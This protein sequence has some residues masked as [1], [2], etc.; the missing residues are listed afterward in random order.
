M[1]TLGY[2]GL[3]IPFHIAKKKVPFLDETGTVQQP[4]EPNAVKFEMFIFDV[5]PMARRVA[6]VETNRNEE[7]L[8][9]KDAEGEHSPNSVRAAMIRR[10]GRWLKHAGIEF[11]EDEAGNPKFPIEI[12]PLLATQKEEFAKRV[13]DRDPVKGP[14]YY[15]ADGRKNETRLG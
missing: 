8:P 6:V 15:G 11:P 4:A 2:P 13:R 14:A 10:A 1:D 12:S 5:L 7:Y 3:E 9:V